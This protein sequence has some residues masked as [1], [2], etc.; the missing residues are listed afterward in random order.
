[1]SP[2]DKIAW[3]QI[4]DRK[5]LGVRSKGKD[6]FY[7]P[8]GKR[9]GNETN[10]QALARELKEEITIDLI[11]NTLTYLETFT[12]QAHGKPEGVMVEIKCYSGEYTGELKPQSEIEEIGW[13]S[14]DYIREAGRPFRLI[15]TWLQEKNLID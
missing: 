6:T 5:V 12:A 10:E 15:L 11:P 13:L 2:I 3:I 4:K 1:M 7:T 8:G 9:E 14:S